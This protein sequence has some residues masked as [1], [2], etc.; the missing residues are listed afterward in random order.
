M[1]LRCPQKLDLKF[2]FF[3]VPQMTLP[4]FVEWEIVGIVIYKIIY[5]IST[6]N[7]LFFSG[8]DRE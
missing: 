4:L 3:G 2:N 8:G 1:R 6:G 5:Y 7:L